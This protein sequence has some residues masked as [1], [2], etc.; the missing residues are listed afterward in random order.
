MEPEKLREMVSENRELEQKLT[1]RNEQY[2]FDLKKSMSAANFSEEEKTVALHD[3]LP[4]LV[5]GQK[6][7]TTARQLFGTV[8]ECMD[9][10]INKP[11]ESSESKPVFI[12]LDNFL[13]MFGIFAVIL[14]A[15]GMFMKQKNQMQYGLITLLV[16]AGIGA[17]VMYLMYKYIYQYDRPGADKSKKPKRW[18][19]MLILTAAVLVWMLVFMVAVAI[20]R[21]VNPVLDPIIMIVIGAAALGLRYYLKKKYHIV[22]SFS[23]QQQPRK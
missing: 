15:L 8:S 23:A 14:N 3:V 22:G 18:K 7:G 6:K 16:G 17:W 4:A 11:A 9:G 13:M 12:W 21:A 2:I 19:S 5:D 20:P 1:K 10:I